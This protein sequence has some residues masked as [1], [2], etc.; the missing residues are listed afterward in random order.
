VCCFNRHYAE[1]SGY[2]TKTTFLSE[3]QGEKEITFYDSVSGKPLFIAP[4][5]RTW[6][7]FVRES[8]AHG[9]PSFRRRF[10]G[11]TKLLY[12]MFLNNF[13][14]D[15]LRII[16]KRMNLEICKH[17]I[18]SIIEQKYVPFNLFKFRYYR[19]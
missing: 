3:H 4:R 16:L 7:E 19:Y 9:W 1:Q 6:S 17:S 14:N 11:G 2:F 10:F 13:S 5:G 8:R 15:D 18:F 12:T